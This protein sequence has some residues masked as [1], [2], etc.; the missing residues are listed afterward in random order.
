[1]KEVEIDITEL[2]SKSLGMAD[3]K[4][5]TLLCDNTYPGDKVIANVPNKLKPKTKVYLMNILK[6]GI[7]RI[8]PKCFYFGDCGGCKHQN[9]SYADQLDLKHKQILAAL[10]RQRVRIPEELP[11]VMPAPQEW[12]Y[13]NKMEFSFSNRRWLTK[14]ETEQEESFDLNFALGMHT[15]HT[16]DKVL[17]INQCFLITEQ[18]PEILDTARQYA[19]THNLAP[20]SMYD[21]SGYL[22]HLCFRV[23]YYTKEIMLNFVTNTDEPDLLKP[24]AEILVSKFPHIKSIYNTYHPGKGNITIGEKETLLFGKP[25][26]TEQL[27]DLKFEITPTS[28]FQPNTQAAEKVYTL[29]KDF[30]ELNENDTIL[31]LYSGVGT[32]SLYLAQFCKSVYGFEINTSAVESASANKTLNNIHNCEFFA[33]D[34]KDIVKENQNFKRADI[35]AIVIDPPRT[36]LH[37]D[38]IRKLKELKIKKIIYVSCNPLTLAENLRELCENDLYKVTKI[39]PI[40]ML[41]QTYHLE[42]VTRLDLNEK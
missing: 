19:L 7:K 13:R 5:R 15:P 16:F 1:M 21:H 37:P 34:L 22:R 18:T 11:P 41:P 9:I 14:K 20:Y 3:Y 8:E 42:C 17:D 35:D 40:D 31:D 38:V 6:E 12:F 4:N 32:I 39:Q 25:T 27:F 2:D 29:I 26:I 28:F 36:G 30:I 23:S 24:L 33:G 10:K